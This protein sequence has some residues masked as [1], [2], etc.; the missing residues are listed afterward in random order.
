MKYNDI[1]TRFNKYYSLIPRTI[2]PSNSFLPRQFIFEITYRCNFRCPVCQFRPI[3]KKKNDKNS[4]ELSTNQ[5]LKCMEK[6]PPFSLISLTGGEPF[7]RKDIL[8]I[9]KRSAKFRRIHVITN[10]S[11]L[12]NEIAYDLCHLAIKNPLTPGIVGVDISYYGKLSDGKI[13][14]NPTTEG[15]DSILNAKKASRKKFPFINLKMVVS[16]ENIP[17]L[18]PFFE[19]AVSKG[20]DVCSYLLKTSSTN[21]DRHA[22]LENMRDVEGLEESPP[23]DLD[24]KSERLLKE[25]LLAVVELAERS[26]VQLRFSPTVPTDEFFDLLIGRS[27]YEELCCYAPWTFAAISACGDLFPCSNFRLG[28]LLDHSLKELW[29]SEKMKRFRRTIK[30]GLLPNCKRCCYLQKK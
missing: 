12:T 28:N 10:G 9:L 30:S 17:M 13:T 27:S 16:E 3:L 19:Y 4:E 29:H 22:M 6:L 24:K 15:L 1:L 20:V 14:H 5:V 11:L 8:E 26:K 25:Q 18:L 2:I 21:F 7:V 23:L